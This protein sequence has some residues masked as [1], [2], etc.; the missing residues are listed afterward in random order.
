MEE[1]GD[2]YNN[3][4]P[5]DA[6]YFKKAV[7]RQDETALCRVCDACG[8]NISCKSIKLSKAQENEEVP[9]MSSL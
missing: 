5:N 4:K 7:P 6:N 9:Q 3:K 1:A 8:F 2:G